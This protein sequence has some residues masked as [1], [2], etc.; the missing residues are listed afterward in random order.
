VIETSDGTLGFLPIE[1]ET[2]S[3]SDLAS[4]TSFYKAFLNSK[5]IFV[6]ISAESE[7]TVLNFRSL[8]IPFK[9]FI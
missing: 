9:Y 3:R 6:P 5:M 8:V 4:A 1:H 2:P 7:A